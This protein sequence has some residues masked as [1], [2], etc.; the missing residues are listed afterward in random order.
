MATSLGSANTRRLR[1]LRVFEAAGRT[2]GVLSRRELLK[3]GVTRWEIRAEV[4]AGRWRRLGRQTIWIRDGD[5]RLADWWRALHEVGGPAVLDGISALLA[6]GLRTVEGDAVHVAVPKSANPRHCRGVVV[7]ETRRYEPECVVGGWV[8]RMKP[9]TA[10]VHAA[11][12][13]RSDRQA[14]LYV[15][16]AAQ[17]RLFTAQE[18]ADEVAKVRRDKRRRLLRE[19]YVDITAGIESTGERDFAR[20]CRARGYPEPTRQTVRYTD[21]GRLVY[22]NDFDPY[23]VTAEIDGSQ[24]LDPGSWIGDALKQ[25][26]VSIEGRV[27]VRIPNLALRLCPD[28]F[29]AQLEQALRRGGWPGPSAALRPRKRAS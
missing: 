17:Q 18:F 29:F 27:V 25:N 4:A 15:L 8:P 24:H 26:A 21:S 10:A 20:M 9:A 5:T 6:A 28:P 14:A 11:L 7:H 23:D 3:L 12:W 1:R 2:G 13:A 16:A 19:L 22:D